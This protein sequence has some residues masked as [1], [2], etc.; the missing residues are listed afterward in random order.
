MDI[1]KYA[2]LYATTYDRMFQRLSKQMQE[3]VLA[4]KA[5]NELV[6]EE[7]DA[8]IALVMERA[9][10]KENDLEAKEVQSLKL[11]NAQI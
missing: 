5:N 10:Q 7:V 11:A 4:C 1:T 8:F 6:D 9:E 2:E 3:R